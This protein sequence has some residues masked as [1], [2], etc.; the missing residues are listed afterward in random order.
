M[1]PVLGLDR[2]AATAQLEQ[3][4]FDVEV[5]PE[6]RFSEDVPAGQ[7]IDQRPGPNARAVRDSTVTL[8]LSRG[9]DRR[10]V[11]ELGGMDRAAAEAALTAVGLRLGAVTEQF[12]EAPEGTVIATDPFTGDEL[13]PE[14]AVSIVLSK[15]V[16]LLPVPDVGGSPTAEASQRSRR[17][18][19]GPPRPRSSARPSTRGWSTPSSRPGP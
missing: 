18:G 8:V 15:G 1:P 4:G 12:S 2:A 5:D 6:Q 7:V 13:R 9:P 17:P 16:E 3:A 11:P 14:A 10:P 19:S